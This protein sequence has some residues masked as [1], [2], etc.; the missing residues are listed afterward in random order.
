MTDHYETDDK[1]YLKSAYQE[2]CNTYH[3]IDDFRAKLL[4]F[5]PLASGA[6]IFFLSKDTIS[7]NVGDN[8]LAYAG[9]LGFIITLGLLIFEL[10]GIQRCIR[11]IS[12]GKHLEEKMKILGQFRLMPKSF[13]YFIDVPLAAGIIYPA[14]LAA[15]MFL[16]MHYRHFKYPCLA[17]QVA[18]FVFF[19]G[20][21]CVILFFGRFRNDPEYITDKEDAIKQKC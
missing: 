19:I 15:W 10:H 8:V 16:F 5:L 11:I 12:V 17:Y 2:T 9:L 3:S 1:E 13:L 21:I 18:I 20:L 14:V 7:N 4:G 6:G